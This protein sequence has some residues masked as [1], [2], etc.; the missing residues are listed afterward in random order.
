MLFRVP[1]CS[2]VCILSDL[3]RA[4][5]L[6]EPYVLVLTIEITDQLHFRT[7]RLLLGCSGITPRLQVFEYPINGLLTHL[8]IDGPLTSHH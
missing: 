5:L 3:I 1:S 4:T 2:G 8:S 6:K 7:D